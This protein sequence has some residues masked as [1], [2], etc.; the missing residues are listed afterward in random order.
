MA[1][2]RTFQYTDW[3]GKPR[4]YSLKPEDTITDSRCPIDNT[5]LI[6]TTKPS[7]RIWDHDDVFYCPF[8]NN[9][10]H[11]L[12]P[13][14]LEHSRQIILKDLTERLAKLKRQEDYLQKLMD[15]AQSQ[16]KCTDTPFSSGDPDYP[17]YRIQ[18]GDPDYP[19]IHT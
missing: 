5:H 15:V 7:T 17:L 3:E 8:C 4:E 16:P 6:S 13:E 14:R 12:E 11:S 1:K 2:L 19:T 10:Y 18:S 9:D